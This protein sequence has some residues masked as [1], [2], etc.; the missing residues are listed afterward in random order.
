MTHTSFEVDHG[1]LE[2]RFQGITGEVSW[3]IERH[4]AW[5]CIKSRG[6][7]DARGECGDKMSHERRL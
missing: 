2:W 6:M 3:L 4:P 5:K 1:R 7:I